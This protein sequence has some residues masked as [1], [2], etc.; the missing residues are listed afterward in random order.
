MSESIGGSTETRV[1]VVDYLARMRQALAD[2]PSTEVADILEDVGAHVA[3]VSAELGEDSSAQSLADRLG[4][5]ETYAAELRTAAGYPTATLA[6]AAPDRSSMIARLAIWSLAIV[7]G[8]SF[9][10]GLA[11]RQTGAAGFVGSA[12]VLAVLAILPLR[13]LWNGG[14]GWADMMRQPEL[15]RL[16]GALNPTPSSRTGQVLAYVR[17]LRTGWWLVRGL[18]L[19]APLVLVFGYRLGRSPLLLVLVVP[20]VLA[21]IWLGRRSAADR[22]LLGLVLP[23][24]AF[25]LGVGLMFLSNGYFLGYYHSGPTQL[26]YSVQTGLRNN[27]QP[28]EN[29]YFFDANGKPLENVYVY[30]DHGQ[31]INAPREYCV[32]PRGDNEDNLFP[33]PKISRDRG[34]MCQSTN[35]VPFTVAIPKSGLPTESATPFGSGSPTPPPS[36]V[37]SSTAPS[38]TAPSSGVPSSGVPSSPAPTGAAPSS[39]PP[40]G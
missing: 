33:R 20:L 17:S 19:A 6:T 27:G 25:L 39:A 22:R 15:R 29:M 35:G 12:M 23:L 40:T 26:D 30:D 28:L 3:E 16:F 4:T 24:N 18:L 10:L 9:L 34:G 1:E 14:T 5:P 38:G 8:G 11:F 7:T 13:Q 32:Y 36:A 37:P 2:L 21:S 31:P